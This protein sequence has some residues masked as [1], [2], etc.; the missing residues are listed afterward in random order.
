MQELH[1]LNFSTT[2][3][4]LP[5]LDSNTQRC[6]LVLLGRSLVAVASSI[7]IS[8]PSV[9]GT[10][11]RARRPLFP[12]YCFFVSS[13]VFGPWRQSLHGLNFYQHGH[14]LTLTRL[15]LSRMDISDRD[16]RHR[17]LC[18]FLSSSFV[19]SQAVGGKPPRLV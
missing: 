1:P 10:R 9:G 5:V 17:L 2:I 13:A 16:L 18:A 6:H 15:H 11:H 19:S 8:Y 4:Q 3:L 14:L 7:S 12:R